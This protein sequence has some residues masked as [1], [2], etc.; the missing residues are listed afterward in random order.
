MMP[1]QVTVR[2]IPGSQALEEHIRRKAEKLT[3]F[4]GQIQNCHVV[5]EL[6]QKHK[7]QGKLFRVHI[8]LGVPGKEL[9]VDRKQDE[10]VYIAVRNAFNALKRQISDYVD[11]R[12]GD[13]KS[14]DKMTRGER[15]SL[16]VEK[17]ESR[18]H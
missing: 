2:D 14:H 7:H 13:V 18:I 6:P 12:R 9:V 16:L 8:D 17:E 4:Y 1:I 5:V 10:D 3:Q 11:R 15:N